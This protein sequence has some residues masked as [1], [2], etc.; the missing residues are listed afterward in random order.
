MNSLTRCDQRA[1]LGPKGFQSEH[2][3]HLGFCRWESRRFKC[4]SS[5][6]LKMFISWVRGR[7]TSRVL[8]RRCVDATP[9]DYL[10]RSS[11]NRSGLRDLAFA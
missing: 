9:C 5:K 11:L 7:G 1:H 10:F 3:E 4:P 8:R 6:M 2:L